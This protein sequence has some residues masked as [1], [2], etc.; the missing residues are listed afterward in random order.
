LTSS[1]SEILLF[2][3][4]LI[5]DD[6]FPGFLL[7]NSMWDGAKVLTVRT[8]NP[9]TPFKVLGSYGYFWSMLSH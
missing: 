4:K 9:W 7:L 2:G 3:V 8:E 5:N 1:L 6:T